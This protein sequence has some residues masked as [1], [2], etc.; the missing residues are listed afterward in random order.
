MPMAMY[1]ILW[2]GKS[3]RIRARVR[4]YHMISKGAQGLKKFENP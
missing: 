2:I 4:E 3:G 1:T